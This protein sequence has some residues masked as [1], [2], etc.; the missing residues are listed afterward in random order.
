[1]ITAFLA[2]TKL[3]KDLPKQILMAPWGRSESVHGPVVVNETTQRLLPRLQQLAGFK[4]IALDFNHNT[5]PGTD[6][7][8]AEKGEPRKIAA[9]GSPEV[10]AGKGLYFNVSEWTPEGKDAVANGHFPDISPAVKFNE[11]RE[12][13]F[14]HSCAVC[15]Q[16]SIDGLH[17]FSADPAKLLEAISTFSAETKTS[18]MNHK[19]LLCSLLGLAETATDEQIASGVKTFSANVAAVAG[20]KGQVETFNTT[21]TSLAK[22]LDDADRQAIK[23]AALLAGK[24]VPLS[25]ETLPL[26]QFKAIVAELPAD[27]VPL[28][29]RTVEGVKTFAATGVTAGNSADEEVRK[30]LGISAEKWAAAK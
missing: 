26:D 2:P 29:K 3:A 9:M 23:S 15:R 22:R 4:D 12:V 6:A 18:S 25:A 8:A 7:Y 21:L 13:I 16:G 11:E 17:V 5:V 28:A 20:L 30:N 14:A 10:I 24:V 1:M 19:A 27:Q